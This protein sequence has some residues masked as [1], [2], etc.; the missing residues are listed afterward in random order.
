MQKRKRKTMKWKQIKSQF[1]NEWVLI[2]VQKFDENY[3]LIEGEVLY[4]HKDKREVYRKM[5]QLHGDPQT[6]LTIEYT[7]EIPKDLAVML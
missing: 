1:D 6:P 4:H 2:A 7:G 3:E 5:A